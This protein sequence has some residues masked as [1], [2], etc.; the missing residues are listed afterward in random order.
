MGSLFRGAPGE[1]DVAVEFEQ[2]RTLRARYW[3][4]VDTKQWESFGALF[5][6]DATY[7]DHFGAFHCDGASEIAAM[8]AA[9]LADNVV[10]VHHGHQSELE[11]IDDTHARGVWAMEDYVVFP[12]SANHPTSGLPISTLRGSGHYF[13]EYVKLDGNWHFQKIELRRLRV[14]AMNAS[15]TQYPTG[16]LS[17]DR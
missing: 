17:G 2:L 9:A 15:H 7:T 4:Y 8:V 11:L 14:E 1:T 13:D 3:R 16:F 10:S 5:A 12:A 6:P